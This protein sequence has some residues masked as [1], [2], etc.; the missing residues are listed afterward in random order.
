MGHFAD[1]TR[2]M[3]YEELRQQ[4]APALDRRWTWP[5][6]ISLMKGLG[7]NDVNGYMTAGWWV[8]MEARTDP[9]RLEELTSRAEEAVA[10]GQLPPPET[11]YGWQEIKTLARLCDLT[12]ADLV[13]ALLWA[14]TLTMAEDM[15]KEQLE[16]VAA[17]Q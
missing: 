8:P 15:F 9:Q 17:E 7:L 10:G 12:P 3:R 5:Q 16:A 14:Y 11:E 2:Q 13:R 4:L 6:F 1:L